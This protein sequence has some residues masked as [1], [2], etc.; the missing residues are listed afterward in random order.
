MSI[1]ETLGVRRVINAAAAQTKLGGSL[2]PPPVLAAMEDAAGS[3]ID[4][5]ELHDR[6]GERIAAL[7]RNEAACVSC[8]AAAGILQAV[9]A[10]ITGADPARITALPDVADCP[11][12][13][14]VYFRGQWN[15]FLSAARETGA[16]LVE[17]GE[18][19]DELVNAVTERT[20]A[21]IW[22]ASSLFE[23]FAPPLERIVAIAHERDVPV[24]V[25]AA[26]QTPPVANLWYFTTEVGA[27]L[28]IFSGGKG[29]RGPQSSG[30]ILGRRDL[31]ASCRANGGPFHSVGRPAKVGKEELV[32]V[33]AAVEWSLALDEPDVLAGYDAIVRRWVDGLGALPGVSAERIPESHTGQPIPRAVLHAGDGA[34]R[35]ALIESL[36]QHDPRIAVLP[37]GEDGIAFNPQLL[38]PGEADVVLAALRAVVTEAAPVAVPVGH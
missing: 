5:P 27:D 33:L 19:E 13:E 21:V 12:H 14:V 9:A 1:Y 24:I 3:F 34:R 17:V 35:D 37:E 7:T 36:W 25:D 2:M 26:N 32:G 28:A 23:P 16:T 38:E 10:C 31:I 30:L 8:G 15:G 20:A 4:L 18:T 11:R 29:L 22:F 6:V